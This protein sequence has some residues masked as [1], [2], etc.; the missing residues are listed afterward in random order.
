[1]LDGEYYYKVGQAGSFFRFKVSTP[2]SMV[3]IL[4]QTGKPESHITKINP[5]RVVGELFP[6]T[7]STADPYNTAASLTI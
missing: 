2:V 3:M 5:A 6:V 1:V 4:E 7:L